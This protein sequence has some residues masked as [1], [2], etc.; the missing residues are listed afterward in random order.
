MILDG[1]LLSAWSLFICLN[2]DKHRFLVKRCGKK[3]LKS[4]VFLVLN[5][6]LTCKSFE[7]ASM[8]SKRLPPN[9]CF[10]KAINIEMTLFFY[11]FSCELLWFYTVPY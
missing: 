1:E 8:C 4:D 2:W 5:V 7:F 11:M 10:A 9:G 3:H 6:F